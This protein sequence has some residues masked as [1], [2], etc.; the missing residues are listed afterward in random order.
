MKSMRVSWHVVG[1]LAA[2]I[3]TSQCGGDGGGTPTTPGGSGGTVNTPPAPTIV[4]VSISGTNGNKSYQP[5]PVPTNVGEQVA[6]RNNDTVVHHIV[7]DDGSADFGN[8][9]PGATSQAR[10]ISGG[11]FHCVN[12]PSMV[13]A[14]NALAAPEPPPGSGDGY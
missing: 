6:F 11:N 3:A 4:T 7:M 9:A 13:G 2:A 8:L 14:V 10:A 1:V 12:H 5:N